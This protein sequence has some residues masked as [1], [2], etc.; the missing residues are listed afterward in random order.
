ML[1]VREEKEKEAMKKY[2]AWVD[3]GIQE[4]L[5]YPVKKDQRNPRISH[6]SLQTD[7][8][9]STSEGKSTS[10]ISNSYNYLET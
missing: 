9:R 7:F 4:T 10:R 5:K 1:S 6:L 2:R 3:Y 8:Y